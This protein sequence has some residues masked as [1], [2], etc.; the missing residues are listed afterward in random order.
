M[1]RFI[2]VLIVFPA[3]FCV[4]GELRA[5]DIDLKVIFVTAASHGLDESEF[6]LRR[7]GHAAALA[8]PRMPAAIDSGAARGP[9]RPMAV[10]P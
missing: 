10:G 4:T 7:K 6:A 8:D 1:M 3:L 5:D 9:A 2:A